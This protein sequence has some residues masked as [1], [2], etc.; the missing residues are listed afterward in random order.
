MKSGGCA[1]GGK[2][3]I[4]KSEYMTLRKTQ[5]NPCRGVPYRRPAWLRSTQREKTYRNIVNNP[6]NN[7]NKRT[8]LVSNALF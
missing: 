3:Q 7:V 1:H 5:A 4:S 8:I 2:L 6:K